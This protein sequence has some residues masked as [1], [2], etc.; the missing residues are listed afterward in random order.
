MAVILILVLFFS[1]CDSIQL[2]CHQIR[3]R[4]YV[5]CDSAPSNT[6]ID[7]QWNATGT[8]WMDNYPTGDYACYVPKED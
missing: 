7:S 6:L 1:G 4:V 8:C 5:P 2:V 3:G